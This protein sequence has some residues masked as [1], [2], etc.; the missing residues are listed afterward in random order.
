MNFD[1]WVMGAVALACLPMFVA[2]RKIGRA[3]GLLFI[4]YYVAYVAYLIFDARSHD[5][6]PQFSAIMV[7]FVLPLTI[8][9]LI[10]MVVRDQR[11]TTHD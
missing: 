5:A 3:K 7:G 2:G 11:T 8:V 9:T 6:L 4:A 1:I 10:A